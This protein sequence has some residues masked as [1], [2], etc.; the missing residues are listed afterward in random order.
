MIEIH[1]IHHTET[2][3]VS[4]LKLQATKNDDATLDFLTKLCSVIL[5]GGVVVMD[6]GTATEVIYEASGVDV[7]EVE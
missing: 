5:R 3:K 2:K 7:V 6:P 1:F 4:S